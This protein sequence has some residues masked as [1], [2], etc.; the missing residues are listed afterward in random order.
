MSAQQA[1]ADIKAGVAL[2]L[3]GGGARGFAHV[4]VWRALQEH[5]IP[6]R[7]VSGTSAGAIAGAFMAAGTGWQDA[8]EWMRNSRYF[9]WRNFLWRKDG[10]FTLDPLAQILRQQLPARFEEL[11]IPFFATATDLVKGEAVHFSSGDLCEALLASAAVPLVFEP[12]RMNGQLL[13]DGGVM[14]NFP[15]EPLRDF[16][17]PIFGVHVNRITARGADQDWG[18]FYLAEKCFHLAIAGELPRKIACCHWFIEPAGDQ[19]QLFDFDRAEEIMES[20]YR[21]TLAVLEEALNA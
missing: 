6:V 1:V 17:Y 10:L 21:A 20:G 18:K 14:N 16:P 2:A 4:G 9:G 7:A 3:S 8:F 15:V 19:Y 5:D 12:R 13:V 11:R